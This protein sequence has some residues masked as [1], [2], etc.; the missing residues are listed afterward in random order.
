MAAHASFFVN[1][2]DSEIEGID[3]AI[4]SGFD[5][6]GGDLVVDFRHNYN[7]QEVSDVD[8]GTI[9]AARVFDLENQIPENRSLL[10]FNWASGGMFGALLRLNYYDGWQST[11]GLF[12]DGA[13][14]LAT[15]DYGSTLLVDAEVSMTFNDMFTV[16]LG[17]ENL[18]DEYPD[19][20]GDAT[21]D[22]L[23]VTYAVTSPWG[24]NGGFYYLRL[25]AGF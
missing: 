19:D 2:Y 24:F 20:E 6:G 11:G 22:A 23:G 17:G 18:F 7:T 5:L 1:G 12:D 10:S 21:L 13:P 8:T 25:S 4:T 15:F 3:L 14:P 16:T 9:N